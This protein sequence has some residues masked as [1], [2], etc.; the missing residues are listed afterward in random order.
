M[1]NCDFQI[2]LDNLLQ[3]TS[4]QLLEPESPG[5]TS[6]DTCHTGPQTLGLRTGY[7]WK[8]P[9]VSIRQKHST[10]R[11]L[12]V[13]VQFSYT[14]SWDPASK[15]KPVNVLSHHELHLKMKMTD[16]ICLLYINWRWVF[17]D[18]N[19]FRRAIRNHKKL[20]IDFWSLTQPQN[21]RLSRISSL[22]QH[23]FFLNKL[24]KS[25]VSERWFCLRV[26]SH[27]H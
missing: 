4:D 26:Q 21:K 16:E 3:L 22:Q 12:H 18:V 14:G 25:H 8:I 9:D 1:E 15:V 11:S 20:Q 19:L 7:M 24:C 23:L 10:K 2:S 27:F 6:F 5:Q 17:C 13:S